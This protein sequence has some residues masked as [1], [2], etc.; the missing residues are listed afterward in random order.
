MFVAAC[1]ARCLPNERARHSSARQAITPARYD[2]GTL[3]TNPNAAQ[4]IPPSISPPPPRFLGYIVAVGVRTSIYR[5]KEYS[6][7]IISFYTAVSCAFGSPV[8]L[9][10]IYPYTRCIAYAPYESQ[11]GQWTRSTLN[12]IVKLLSLSCLSVAGWG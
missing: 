9:K 12:A 1:L 4:H 8:S 3:A 5:A 6:W 11:F 10:R 7:K 2:E